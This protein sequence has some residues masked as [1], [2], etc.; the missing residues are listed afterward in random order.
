MVILVMCGDHFSK[1]LPFRNS[2]DHQ[3]IPVRDFIASLENRHL[4]GACNIYPAGYGS[5]ITTQRPLGFCWF[6][7]LD[8]SIL[9]RTHFRA[10]PSQFNFTE[11]PNDFGSELGFEWTHKICPFEYVTIHFGSLLIFFRHWAILKYILYI[12]ICIYTYKANVLL[13]RPL[14]TFVAAFYEFLTSATSTYIYIHLHTYIYIH[15]CIIPIYIYTHTS[16]CVYMYMNGGQNY[17][18]PRNCHEQNWVVPYGL[19][20]FSFFGNIQ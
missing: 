3:I 12:Y 8:P 9:H 13:C 15:I 2:T 16:V 1:P 11:F 5:K 17:L 6:L 4:H 19:W 14:V 18:F 7:V 20:R 10:S